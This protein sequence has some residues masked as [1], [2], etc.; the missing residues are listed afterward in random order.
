MRCITIRLYGPLNDFVPRE[1]RHVAWP[2]VFE[3]GASAKDVIEGFG[4]PH[5]EVDLVLVNGE[6][7]PFEYAV[8]DGDRLAVFPRFAAIDVSA[9]TR[10]R[11]QLPDPI[12]FVLDIHL[13]KLARHL[14]LA[15]LDVAYRRDA[16]DD[17]LVEMARRDRRILLT[18]D[19]GLLKRRAVIHG[20]FVR[21]TAAYQ[22]LVEVLAR[23]SPLPLAPFSRCPGCNAGL[24]ETP[25][26]TIEARLADRTRRAFE[27]FHECAGCGQ[28]YWKGSHWPELVRI[29][30][31][32]IRQA[33]ASPTLSLSEA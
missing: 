26:A 29:L 27:Q 13:G 3:G 1:R 31:A 25:K 9:V 14:R 23:F 11:Q 12:R 15:G 24:R 21:E 16:R 32:A 33:Q 18:R 20:Y 28:I 19:R 10:V 6:S 7:V 5:P 30:D 2:H 4:V 8:Q 22:Q 17:E